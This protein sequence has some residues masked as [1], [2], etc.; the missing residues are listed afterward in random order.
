ME[1]I[2]YLF[3]KI[4][5]KSVDF[6]NYFFIFTPIAILA[7]SSMLLAAEE[8]IATI[9]KKTYNGISIFYT[10]PHPAVLASILKGLTNLEISY[11]INPDNAA[12]LKDI[13]F[14]LQDVRFLKQA[15]KFKENS[16]I[17]KI[18]VGPNMFGRASEQNHILT[19]NVI[20]IYLTPSQWNKIGHIEDEPKVSRI[21]HVWP[22]GVDQEYWK[23]ENPHKTNKVL[24]Y[25]K[26]ESEEFCKEVEKII[27]KNGWQP[28]IL[29]Y[30]DYSKEKYKKILNRVTYAVFISVSE[31][32]GI[33]LAECWAMNVPTLVWNPEEPIFYLGKC[34]SPVSS[35]PYLTK[36]TG[37]S[38]KTLPELNE[39]VQMIPGNLD[40]FAPRKWVIN[41]MTDTI[42]IEM[43][44]NIIN[45]DNKDM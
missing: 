17:K 33:A 31:S 24:I 32:Q 35:C 2:T 11:T 26:T 12:Q 40:N 22:A 15:I 4:I 3:F 23:P 41:H 18:I 13:A 1:Q 45:E 38:W 19:N 7:Q 30:G 6:K 14:C 10:D 36:E 16:L 20:D 43:L 25:W 34:F 28:I 44:L 39:L 29:K 5:K 37:I 9:F 27:K 8:S 42:S 21:I